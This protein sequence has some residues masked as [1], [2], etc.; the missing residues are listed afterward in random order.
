MKRY[1]IL[2]LAL[3]AALCVGPQAL[4]GEHDR[5][6][7]VNT[8][9][10]INERDD[11][12]VFDFAFAIRRVAGDVVDQENVALAYSSCERC[13]SVAI[14]IQI[15]LASGSPSIVTPQ[16]VAVAVNEN[17]TLC[18][19]FATAYQFVITGDTELEFTKEGRKELKRITREIR[20][21]NDRR[22]SLDEI[23]TRLDALIERLRVVLRTQLVPKRDRGDDDEDEDEDD[24]QEEQPA[25][26]ATGETQTEPAQTATT[27]STPTETTAT[28]PV[29]TGATTTETTQTETVPTQT[30]P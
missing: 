2:L 9:V 3:L 11:S 27:E 22:L 5:D 16:N 8:A 21:L 24:G 23:R 1:L 28:E 10:V 4:A 15:V 14:A 6:P 12:N 19:T 17:C 30:T 26:T 18:E 29:E 7:D 20:R 13:R 25:L